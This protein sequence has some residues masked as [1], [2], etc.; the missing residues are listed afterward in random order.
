MLFG[1]FTQ[2]NDL[3]LPTHTD[4]RLMAAGSLNLQLKTIREDS[5]TSSRLPEKSELVTR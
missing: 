1:A 5:E 4:V 3:H 2:P